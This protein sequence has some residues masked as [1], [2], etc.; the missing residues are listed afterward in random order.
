MF[1][2]NILRS[3]T[4]CGDR[5]G[6]DDVPGVW[7]RHQLGWPVG[8]PVRHQGRKGKDAGGGRRRRGSVRFL[9]Q[10]GGRQDRPHGVRPEERRGRPLKG[11]SEEHDQEQHHQSDRHARGTSGHCLIPVSKLDLANTVGGQI[12]GPV[13]KILGRLKNAITYCLLWTGVELFC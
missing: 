8:R 12:Y 11:W 1:Q 13:D 2:A 5:L 6:V 3:K 4:S 9:D 7:C 10:P